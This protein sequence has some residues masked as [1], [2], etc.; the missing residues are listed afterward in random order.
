MTKYTFRHNRLGLSL[1][2]HILHS[3][4]PEFASKHP[5]VV[6]RFYFLCFGVLFNDSRILF[7]HTAQ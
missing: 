1:V 7:T 6:S 2:I 5:T 3:N 4:R